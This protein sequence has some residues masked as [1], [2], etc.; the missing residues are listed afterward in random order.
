[1]GDLGAAAPVPVPGSCVLVWAEVGVP[2]V[3]GVLQPQTASDVGWGV[4]GVPL[5][6]CLDEALGGWGCSLVP[7]LLLLPLHCLGRC[8]GQCNGC[9]AAAAAAA[10]LYGSSCAVVARTAA[11]EA[12]S[13]AMTV[14]VCCCCLNAMAA[15][16]G[17]VGEPMGSGTKVKL[18][19]PALR[20][21]GSPVWIAS[22]RSAG[23]PSTAMRR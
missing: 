9:C 15:V 2:G 3:V 16:A 19:A 8:P 12:C 18:W 1:M 20:S 14:A 11:A 6:G 22:E 13:D 5:H 7:G 4:E 21:V 23:V 10:G 17:S